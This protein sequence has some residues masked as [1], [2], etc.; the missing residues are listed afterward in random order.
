MKNLKKL[1]VLKLRIYS[2][3]EERSKPKME[4]VEEKHDKLICE[5]DCLSGELKI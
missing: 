5:E 4:Y 1:L 2:F 3:L